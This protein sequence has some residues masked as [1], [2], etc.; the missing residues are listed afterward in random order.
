MLVW[1][2]HLYYVLMVMTCAQLLFILLLWSYTTEVLQDS[3]L[4][5]ESELYQQVRGILPSGGYSDAPG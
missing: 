4:F 5:V 2:I 1:W 3:I